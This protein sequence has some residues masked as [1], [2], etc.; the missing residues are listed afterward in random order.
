MHQ[1]RAP[2]REREHH[3]TQWV[4]PVLSRA[5]RSRIDRARDHERAEAST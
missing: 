3:S 2:V 4:W 1:V 5:R